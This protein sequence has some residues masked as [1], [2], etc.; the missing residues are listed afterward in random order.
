MLENPVRKM[1]MKIIEWFI[2]TNTNFSVSFGKE[3]KF[4]KKY[5]TANE[6]NTILTTYSDFKPENIWTSLFVMTDLLANLRYT[7]Q[8]N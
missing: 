3:G 6:Y 5:L 4:M 1:F 7:L 2:G 8:K